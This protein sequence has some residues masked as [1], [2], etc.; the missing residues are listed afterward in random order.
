MKRYEKIGEKRDVLLGNIL[1][2]CE[3]EKGKSA[4]DVYLSEDDVIE[5]IKGCLSCHDGYKGK[6]LKI[7]HHGIQT[8]LNA[9]KNETD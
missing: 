7:F 3:L 6:Y 4:T 5:R 9:I 1:E 2:I 8:V